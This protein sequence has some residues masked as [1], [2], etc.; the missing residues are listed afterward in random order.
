[1]A[2][3]ISRQGDAR[4]KIQEINRSVPSKPRSDKQ[5]KKRVPKRAPKPT[6]EGLSA[7]TKAEAQAIVSMGKGDVSRRLRNEQR[8][9]GRDIR[10]TKRE[11]GRATPGSLEYIQLT[12]RLGSLQQLQREMKASVKIAGTK[13][14][15]QNSVRIRA[16][17]TYVE[18]YKGKQRLEMAR[19]YSP[20]MGL[21]GGQKRFYENVTKLYGEM[22]EVTSPALEQLE[23]DLELAIRMYDSDQ[24]R[25]II[26]RAHRMTGDDYMK[27][28]EYT[29]RFGTSAR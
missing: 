16:M 24:A 3:R 22:P 6:L 12:K 10:A 1:M 8:N 28:R 20:S 13:Q 9:I 15:N 23:Q 14:A 25:E 19:T 27:T 29:N 17:L 4:K 2:V 21:A 5:D 7:W 18:D 26:A 11:I